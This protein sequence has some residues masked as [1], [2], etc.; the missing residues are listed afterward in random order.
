MNPPV[1]LGSAAT[2]IGFVLF[3]TLFT[4]LTEQGFESIQSFIVTTFGWFYI[5]SVTGL[6]GIIIWLL[7]SRYGNIRLGGEDVQPEFGYL[8]WFSMMMSAGMGIGVVFF[9]VAEPM[10]HY[11]PLSTRRGR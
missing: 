2:V 3:G 5:L 11:L 9:G 10:L 8:T 7:F 6:L 4:D 1:F